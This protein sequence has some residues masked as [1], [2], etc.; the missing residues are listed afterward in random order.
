MDLLDALGSLRY[1]RSTADK[2]ALAAAGSLPGAPKDTTADLERGNRYAS[3][4][5]FGQN[6][7]NL[8]P[9]VQPLIDTIKTSDL[10][11]LGGSTPELQSFASEGVSRGASSGPAGNA[12]VAA[13]IAKLRGR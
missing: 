2:E 11:L 6:W 13:L 12:I 3:G 1:G 8:A 9:A 4:Y 5:L 7:P 10:P